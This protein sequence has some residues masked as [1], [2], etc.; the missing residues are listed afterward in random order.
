MRRIDILKEAHELLKSHECNGICT[1]IRQALDNN[2]YINYRIDY[3]IPLFNYHNA[4]RFN[5][6]C[7]NPNK[8]YWWKYGRYGIFNGR[9]RFMRWLMR[10]YKYD[11][12]EIN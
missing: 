12:E 8:D 4:K 6:Y 10:K 11:K 7:P 2:G 9:R 3:Y 1:A 5:A